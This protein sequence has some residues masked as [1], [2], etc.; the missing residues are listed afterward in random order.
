MKNKEES[1]I[2]G[3]ELGRL[4][5]LGLFIFLANNIFDKN[6]FSSSDQI[7]ALIEASIVIVC[8]ILSSVVLFWT[9]L[10]TKPIQIHITILNKKTNRPFT[11]IY[12]YEQINQQS[13]DKF[14]LVV[15]I[16]ILKNNSLWHSFALKRVKN[17]DVKLCIY[18][19]QNSNNYIVLQPKIV[20]SDI[21]RVNDGFNI[22]INS[23]IFENLLLNIPYEKTY[24]CLVYENRDAA[25]HP[26]NRDIT[27]CSYLKINESF[28]F[29]IFRKLFITCVFKNDLH[30]VEYYK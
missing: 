25:I 21:Q 7:K 28:L 18:D 6:T 2:F 26:G 4:L 3:S 22:K 29:K 20:D 10:I 11:Q 23:L 14:T 30:K 12:H 8:Y 24:E 13:E 19:I 5:I 1:N 15:N 27:V 9:R 16:K 17:K